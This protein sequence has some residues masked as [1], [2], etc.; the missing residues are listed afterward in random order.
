MLIFFSSLIGFC[1]FDSL[2]TRIKFNGVYYFIH[3]IHNFLIV[4]STLD[5]V[6]NTFSSFK[7]LELFDSNMVA[8]QL[9]FG[10]HFYHLMYYWRKFLFEDWLHHIL[11]IGI[12]LPLGVYLPASTLVGFSLFFTTGLPGGIDYFLLFM[13]RN[14]WLNAMIEKRVNN[15]LNVWIRSAGCSAHAAFVIAYTFSQH[16]NEMNE[17]N[18]MNKIENMKFYASLVTAALTYWNGQ[19]FMERVVCDYAKKT[20]IKEQEHKKELNELRTNQTEKQTNRPII[21]V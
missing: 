11:M 21:L 1:L 6:L 15:W 13:V 8:V 2:L 9:C 10:L 20:L 18:E 5:D 17:L 14:N 19:Y 16:S 3:S 12:A 7:H 4:I